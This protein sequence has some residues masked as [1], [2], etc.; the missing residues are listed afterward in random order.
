[1]DM[2]DNQVCN[3]RQ[4][5]LI[6]SYVNGD[7]KGTY[8]ATRSDIGNYPAGNTLPCPLA[9]TQKLAAVPTRL[10]AMD[11]LTQQQLVNWGYAICDAVAR[12]QRQHG[13]RCVPVSGC[14]RLSGCRAG[15]DP[16]LP[17]PPAFLP[18]VTVRP[19][20]FATPPATR[21]AEAARDGSPP[22]RRAAR[23]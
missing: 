1:N 22:P 20:R 18:P 12:R 8:W 16:V 14:G 17:A 2:I 15:R 21:P 7:R 23:D 5:Q 11:E 19:T 10:A 13:S 9:A 3:L 6:D 4:R